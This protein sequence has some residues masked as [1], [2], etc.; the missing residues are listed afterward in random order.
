M[1]DDGVVVDFQISIDIDAPPETVWSVVTDIERWH[2]WT[3]SIRSIRRLDRGPL[4]VGSRALI[5]QPKLL[6]A[7]WR[8]TA[9]EQGRSFTWK[10]GLP[11]MWV[12]AH[13][14][15][16][17]VDAGSRATLHLQFEGVFGHMMGRA[18]RRIN[19]TYLGMEARG[20]KR[21]SEERATSLART[22]GAAM[23]PPSRV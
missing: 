20:L 14:S 19:E 18:L 21:R 17:P 12:H 15:V 22:T 4:A 5:R 23:P 2:E 9:I 8:V 6:P 7:M 16:A 11:L 13:H 1:S 3:A 10:S